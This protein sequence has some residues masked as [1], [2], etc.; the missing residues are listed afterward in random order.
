[1]S[2]RKERNNDYLNCSLTGEQFKC[3]VVLVCDGYSYEKEAL[4]EWLKTNN[5]SPVT[6]KILENKEYIENFD[7]KTIINGEEYEFICPISSNKMSNPVLINTG[8]TFDEESIKKHFTITKKYTNPLTNEVLTDTRLIPNNT[9]RNIIYNSLDNR[10]KKQ[11]ISD[12]IAFSTKI[13]NLEILD[14]V[15]EMS[16]NSYEKNHNMYMKICK[17]VENYI[18]NNNNR[19]KNNIINTGCI[20]YIIDIITFYNKNYS[21]CKSETCFY[22]C[23]YVCASNILLLLS[24]TKKSSYENKIIDANGIN[25]IISAIE[26]NIKNTTI[27]VSMCMILCNFSKTFSKLVNKIIDANGIN[28]IINI[29]TK[30]DKNIELLQYANDIL[31]NLAN[32]ENNMKKILLAGGIKA[33]IKNMIFINKKKNNNTNKVIRSCCKTLEKFIV[34]NNVKSS[35][36]IDCINNVIEQNISDPYILVHALSILLSL[37]KETIHIVNRQTQDNKILKNNCIFFR[38]IQKYSN[39]KNNSIQ[40]VSTSFSILYT[41][42]EYNSCLNNVYTY[43]SEYSIIEAMK[44]FSNDQNIQCN[45]IYII[46]Y[47]IEQNKTKSDT[48]ATR[49]GIYVLITAINIHINNTNIVNGALKIL[50]FLLDVNDDTIIIKRLSC[51]NSYNGIGIINIIKVLNNLVLVSKDNNFEDTLFVCMLIEKLCKSSIIYDRIIANNGLQAILLTIQKYKENNKINILLELFNKFYSKNSLPDNI[52]TEDIKSIIYIME[53]Y[54]ND[55]TVQ[56]TGCEILTK[57]YRNLSSNNKTFVDLDIFNTIIKAMNTYKNN[58]ILQSIIYYILA[59]YIYRE[60][61]DAIN[62]IFEIQG[63]TLLIKEICENSKNSIMRNNACNL[64]ANICMFRDKSD[65]IKQDYFS[66]NGFI[67]YAINVLQQDIDT[68]CFENNH[69][70]HFLAKISLNNDKNIIKIV[71]YKGIQIVLTMILNSKKY[72]KWTLILLYNLLNNEDNCLEFA[73]T[74]GIQ[75]IVNIMNACIDCNHKDSTFLNILKILSKL[76]KIDNLIMTIVTAGSIN[77]LLEIIKTSKISIIHEYVS[78]IMINLIKKKDI[79]SELKNLHVIKSPEDFLTKETL[80]RYNSII[81]TLKN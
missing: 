64:F 40:I 14:V 72:N 41:M 58:D 80:D 42:N 1:M 16:N 12:I 3:P 53:K 79:I 57:W 36:S 71:E 33:V 54:E 44:Q 2:K 78:E 60:E 56:I 48:I 7:L 24:S 38:I 31:S 74:G 47:Y 69:V 81:T 8:H 4:C 5:S 70:C 29:I 73:F 76:S 23:F 25:V 43:M 75:I 26:N 13:D 32:T 65:K 22:E 62:K 6:E 45:G 27:L 9:I 49:D 52:N 11:K 55:V 18:K 37:I 10:G 51:I 15:K 66:D 21:D 19:L 28:V 34:Y 59:M 17:V 68:K 39:N 77:H 67:E 46:N 35:I 30:Y 50:N 20:K 63:I 61:Q